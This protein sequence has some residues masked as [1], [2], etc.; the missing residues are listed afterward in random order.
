MKDNF[1]NNYTDQLQRITLHK[2]LHLFF[3]Q[4]QLIDFS[5]I[6]EES[7]IKFITKSIMNFTQNQ[8]YYEDIIYSK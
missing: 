7:I 2:L 5:N 6:I 4:Y 3:N 1:K 8:D